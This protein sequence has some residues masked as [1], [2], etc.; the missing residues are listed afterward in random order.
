MS[1]HRPTDVI[2]HAGPVE[3]PAAS[4]SL[5]PSLSTPMLCWLWRA[6]QARLQREVSSIEM[7]R[8]VR[9]RRECLRLLEA[10]DPVAFRRW[11]PRAGEGAD[12]ADPFRAP[13]GG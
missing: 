7:E 10:R 12:P 2:R 4:S 5:L 9:L 11:L 6:T 8:I 13:L 3:G 1:Q